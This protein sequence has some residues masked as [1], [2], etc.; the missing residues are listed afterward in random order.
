V[1]E[2]QKVMI[3]VIKYLQQNDFWKCFFSI[4]KQH[5]NSCIAAGRNYFEVDHCGSE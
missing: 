3:F 1:E 4:W 2:I 5:W